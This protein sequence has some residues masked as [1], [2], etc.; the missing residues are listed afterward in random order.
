MVAGQNE[1]F[2]QTVD[3][4]QSF[5]SPKCVVLGNFRTSQ[6][7]TGSDIDTCDWALNRGG[8]YFGTLRYIT[9]GIIKTDWRDK[10]LGKTEIGK[11]K[12]AIAFAIAIAI[13]IA[14]YNIT[15][16]NVT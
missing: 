12:I 2:F 8:R 7:Y 16:H 4:F 3:A 6:S 15:E 5:S 11:S 14:I 9:L 13:A 1:F 10:K